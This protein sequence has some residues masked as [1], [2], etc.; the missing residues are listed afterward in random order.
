MNQSGCLQG[1][2][3]TLMAQMLACDTVQLLVDRR[4][5]FFQRLL[6]AGTPFG[7]QNVGSL[8]VQITCTRRPFDTVVGR[9]TVWLLSPTI[10]TPDRHLSLILQKI[11]RNTAHGGL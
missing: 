10:A 6:I 9:R 5:E 7:D 8:F 11:G 3:D 4:Q 1:V 2:I